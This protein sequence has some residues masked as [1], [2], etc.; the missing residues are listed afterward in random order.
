MNTKQDRFYCGVD[1]HTRKMYLCVIT[2]TVQ[3]ICTAIC[4]RMPRSFSTPCVRFATIWSWPLSACFAYSKEANSPRDG[5]AELARW[6]TDLHYS[7]KKRAMCS[8]PDRA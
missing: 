7:Q 5:P 6:T 8:A 2:A 3:F 1:L 4:E